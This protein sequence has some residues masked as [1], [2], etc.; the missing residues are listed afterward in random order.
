MQ[1]EIGKGYL[2]DDGSME[3][4]ALDSE[5]TPLGSFTVVTVQKTSGIPWFIW[6]II[7]IV[8][9]IGIGLALYLIISRKRMV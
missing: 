8:G 3:I 1:L 9:A 4:V 5:G 7:G 6:L 2:G